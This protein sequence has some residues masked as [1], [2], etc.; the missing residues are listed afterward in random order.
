MPDFDACMLFI[1]PISLVQLKY[2][3]LK[4]RHTLKNHVEAWKLLH[5]NLA[6]TCR[7]PCLE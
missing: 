3:G 5:F 6:D 1:P 2:E 4:S 7:N